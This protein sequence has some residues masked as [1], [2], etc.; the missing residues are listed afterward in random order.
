MIGCTMGVT[1]CR[2]WTLQGHP[3]SDENLACMDE[4]PPSEARWTWEW[5]DDIYEQTNAFQV[6]FPSSFWKACVADETGT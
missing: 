2:E 1:K 3:M 6:D 5:M 4:H